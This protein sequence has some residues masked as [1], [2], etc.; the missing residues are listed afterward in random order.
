V[1]I[2]E[3]DAEGGEW[4]VLLTV[5]PAPQS[6][7]ASPGGGRYQFS[8]TD[9]ASQKLAAFT[10]D[11]AARDISGKF[12]WIEGVRWVTAVGPR[13]DVPV[14]AVD[15]RRALW[16]YCLAANQRKGLTKGATVWRLAEISKNH[17]SDNGMQPTAE[18]SHTRGVVVVQSRVL[19]PLGHA[20][21]VTR[22]H[23]RQRRRRRWRCW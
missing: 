22:W 4:Q 21:D 15:L 9:W 23:W 18:D 2:V 6:P 3:S 20:S 10:P 12:Q 5:N 17:R 1:T 7:K 13:R 19:F 16:E 8:K 14:P 11:D